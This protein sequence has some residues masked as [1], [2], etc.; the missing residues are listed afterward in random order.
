MCRAVE[1]LCLKVFLHTGHCSSDPAAAAADGGGE[2]VAKAGSPLGPGV[3]ACDVRICAS[4]AALF[5]KVTVHHEQRGIF[6][7]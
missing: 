2:G 1:R 7:E 3:G 4:R 5:S 6:S